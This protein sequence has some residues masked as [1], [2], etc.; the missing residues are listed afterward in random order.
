M[1]RPWYAAKAR[2]NLSKHGVS[3]EEAE[4]VFSDEDAIVLTDPDHSTTEDRFLM[5]GLS[6][7]LRVLVLLSIASRMPAVPF[8]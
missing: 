5:P 7:A 8:A 3:F 4:T 2:A 1:S 6:V